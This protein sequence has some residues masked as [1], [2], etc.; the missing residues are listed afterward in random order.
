MGKKTFLFTD[1]TLLDELLGNG[2]VCMN[3]ARD[4]QEKVVMALR[5]FLEQKNMHPVIGD[6]SV[7]IQR[8]YELM[9]MKSIPS[10]AVFVSDQIET[11]I[12]PVDKTYCVNLK[13]FMKKDQVNEFLIVRVNDEGKVSLEVLRNEHI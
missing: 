8:R 9:N 12:F 2:K 7:V 13:S 1:S 4:G 5:S 3:D 10:I 11:N 6:K